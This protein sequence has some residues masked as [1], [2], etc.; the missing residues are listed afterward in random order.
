[1]ETPPKYSGTPSKVPPAPRTGYTL[2]WSIEGQ[3]WIFTK[4]AN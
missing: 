1:M 3:E 4:I 2:H